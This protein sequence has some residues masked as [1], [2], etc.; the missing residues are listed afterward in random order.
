M[1]ITDTDINCVRLIEPRVFGD[2]RGY[3][4]ESHNHRVMEAGGINR[5]FVQD[6][7][8]Y[9][10]GGI[11]RG[12][13]YQV[14]DEQA[15]L[16]R[17]VSGEVFDV[18]VDVRRDSPSYSQWVGYT[19]SAT[20]HRMLFIPEG[21]AHGYLTLSDS[22]IVLYK[23]SGYYNPEMERGIAWNDPQ[24]GI[25]WPGCSHRQVISDRDRTLKTL[26]ELGPEDLPHYNPNFDAPKA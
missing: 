14:R 18:A 12:M 8:S 15:K 20:N 7:H 19:L 16:I 24:V 23:C 9:S 4:F 6:N 25:E 2:D 22:A 5:E 11:L 10:H 13:H 1:I 26:A 21:F 3:F 17:V